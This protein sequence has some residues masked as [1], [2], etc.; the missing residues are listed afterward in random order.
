M[1]GLDA[2][3]ADAQAKPP[4]GERAEV[5][6]SMR[7][8]E[9]HAIIAA[10]VGRQAALRPLDQARSENSGWRKAVSAPPRRLDPLGFPHDR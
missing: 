5:E 1:A 2:F 3:Y 9:G 8:G 6:Q 4:D 10:D 7:R